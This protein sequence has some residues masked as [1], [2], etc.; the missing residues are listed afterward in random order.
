MKFSVGLQSMRGQL[1]H[2]I[3][4]NRQHIREVY[5]SWGD[6]PNGR[7][8]QLYSETYTPGQMQQDREDALKQLHKWDIPLNL[9]F[10]ATCP[11]VLIECGFLSNE[12]EES[13]L[14]EK[15]YQNKLSFCIF[16]A[17]MEG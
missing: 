12:E 1:L 6:F 8:S 14:L 13:K 7:S 17:M 4:E 5:F 2:A 16:Y 11:A 10:N 15:D 9:L 3:G